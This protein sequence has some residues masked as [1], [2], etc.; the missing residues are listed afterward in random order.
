MIIRQKG[1]VN[2]LVARL[3]AVPVAQRSNDLHDIYQQANEQVLK[4]V[5]LV[6]VGL[7]CFSF[8]LAIVM[9][10]FM[11]LLLVRAEEVKLANESLERRVQA[12][13]QRCRRATGNWPR[14]SWNASGLR[15]NS[16]KPASAPTVPIGPSRSFW[17]T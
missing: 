15:S 7:F 13:P 6:Q 11:R 16:S 3:L 5:G 17:R 9:V 4:R 1:E 10:N 14:K 8:V 12:A 2:S